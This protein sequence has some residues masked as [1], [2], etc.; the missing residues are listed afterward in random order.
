MRGKKTNEKLEEQ[1]ESLEKALQQLQSTQTQLIHS[2]KMASLGELTSRYAHEIQNPL[3]F[4]NNFSEVNKDLVDELE[5]EIK[6]GDK[7]EIS[8]LLNDIRENEGKVMHHGKRAESHRQKYCSNI[9]AEVKARRNLLI[10]M[11]Y[12]MNTCDWPTTASEPKTNPL[13][14]ILKRSLIQIFRK[15]K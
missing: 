9:L 3:N 2:E 1:K 14:Q 15:L 6:K 4:V 5:E 10:S 13:M 11:H 12:V 8:A 7:E